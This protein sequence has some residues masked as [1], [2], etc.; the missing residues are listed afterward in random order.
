M[1]L[2]H[3]V[4]SGRHVPL[5]FA[6]RDAS[7]GTATFLGSRRVARELLPPGLVP[8]PMGLRGTPVT[9]VMVKYRDT[10]IGPY[11]E[12]A[13]Q[14]TVARAGVVGRV[15]GLARLL[16]GRPD[17]F[18]LAM[19]VNEE[20]SRAVGVEIWG[21]PKT[22]DEL[23]IDIGPQ[24]ARAT[25]RADGKHVLTLEVPVGRGRRMPTLDLYAHTVRDGRPTTTPFTMGAAHGRVGVGG[26]RLSLGDHPRASVLRRLGLRPGALLTTWM[27][28]LTASFGRPT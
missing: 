15:A 7:T 19:P 27:D 22:L 11:D 2:D 9:L 18:T 20:I 6:V 28:D 13:V 4:V 8:V 3:Q 21:F 1:T 26:A 14:L 12:V 5:P 17:T 10:A 23:A 25:W 16:T 24:R